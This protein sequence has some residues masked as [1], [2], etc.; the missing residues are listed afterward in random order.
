MGSELRSRL[1]GKGWGF[2]LLDCW[3]GSCGEL[4]DASGDPRGVDWVILS[5][6]LSLARTSLFLRE[7]C[8]W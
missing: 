8:L 5:I 4:G 2:K 3:A 1:S 7:G 6:S